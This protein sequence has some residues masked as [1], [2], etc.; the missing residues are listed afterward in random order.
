MQIFVRVAALGSLSAAARSLGISQTMATKHVGAIEERLGVKLLHR[1]TRR[2]T[3]TEAGRRYLESAERILAEVE[4]AEATAAAERVEARGML[5]VN[6]P[7][8]FGFREVAPLLAEF[9]RLHPAVTVDLGLNDRFVDLIEE[10]WDIAVRIGRMRDSSMIA[11]RI[12]PCRLAVCASPIYL[13]E[14]GTPQTVADL[15]EHN[16]LGYTLSRS[17]GPDEW[18]FGPEGKVKVPVRGNLRANNGDSLVA[19]AVAGQGLIYEPT[20]VLSGELR[21]GRLVALSLDHPPLELPGVFAVYPA[22]RHPPAKVRA[23]VDFLAQR[24]GS[25]PPWDRGLTLPG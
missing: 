16:C 25:N 13:A 10:G 15:S 7:L 1:T 11:R 5:R 20:F 14:R 22:D 23:F 8:S 21:A 19:A 3:L 6:A 18:S 9:S 24:F 17:L 12:A 2:L 4:E